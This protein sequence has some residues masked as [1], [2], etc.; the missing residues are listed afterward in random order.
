MTEQTILKGAPGL[1]VEIF[2]LLTGT[3]SGGI[4]MKWNTAGSGRIMVIRV[5]GGKAH[6]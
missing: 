6:L 1:S 5:S 3:F 2:F 4:S